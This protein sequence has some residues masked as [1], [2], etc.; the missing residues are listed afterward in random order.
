MRFLQTHNPTTLTHRDSLSEGPKQGAKEPFGPSKNYE[1]LNEY[2]HGKIGK[3]N[4]S[5]AKVVIER[6][7]G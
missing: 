1:E 2:S 4:L 3:T 7:N 5:F 6:G